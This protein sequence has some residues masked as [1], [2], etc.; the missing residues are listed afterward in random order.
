M[1]RSLQRLRWKTTCSLY[2]SKSS[3]L[4][5]S[6]HSNVV[7]YETNNEA[8]VPS[9]SEYPPVKPRFPGGNQWGSMPS[10]VAWHWEG[11]KQEVRKLV[12]AQEKIDY[13]TKESF[14][15]WKFP[16]VQ[17]QPKM[18]DYQ[19]YIMK[20]YRAEG[21]PEIYRS[22]DV[23]QVIKR[24]KISLEELLETQA[25]LSRDRFMQKRFVNAAGYSLTHNSVKEILNMLLECLSTHHDHLL[26]S[27][28]DDTVT[29][30]AFWDRYGVKRL[31]PTARKCDPNYE[32]QNNSRFQAD[33]LINFQL[34]TEN[35]LPEV[36]LTLNLTGN[37]SFSQNQPITNKP[38]T[39]QISQN[40]HCG[41]TTNLP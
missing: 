37:F 3:F 4:Q 6:Q 26:N 27:Q 30:K 19:L 38:M 8:G 1:A 15:T 21:L 32:Q 9:V 40:S 29:V 41:T 13:L 35:P 28:F 12:T 36:T 24:C 34:R 5:R 33:H 2:L 16:D 18:L 7:H 22:F 31:L 14:R 39:Y 11:Q 20:T 23:S 10:K 25:V 17:I